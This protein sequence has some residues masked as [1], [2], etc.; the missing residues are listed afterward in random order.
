MLLSTSR[1]STCCTPD[2]GAIEAGNDVVRMV[3]GEPHSDGGFGMAERTH[4]LG[5]SFRKSIETL[6]I[7]EK[8]PLSRSRFL[9]NFPIEFL[10][11]REFF[12]IFPLRCA[13]NFIEPRLSA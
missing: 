6:F 4:S 5:N 12:D 2:V 9:I 7:R 13:L 3:A 8:T 1:G 11:T 10:F